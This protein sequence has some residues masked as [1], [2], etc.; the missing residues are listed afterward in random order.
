[1]RAGGTDLELDV[2]EHS[3]EHPARRVGDID[4]GQECPGACVDRTGGAGHR[5]RH[6]LHELPSDRHPDRQTDGHV[7]RVCLG[8]VDEHAERVDLRN[9]EQP[10]RDAGHAGRRRRGIVDR[11]AR[12]DQRAHVHVALDHRAV[13]GRQDALERRQLAQSLDV[14]LVRLDIRLRRGDRGLARAIRR[15][16][17]IDDQLGDRLFRIGRLVARHR[18]PREIEVGLLQIQ[19]L[20]GLPEVGFGLPQLLVDLGRRD[21]GQELARRHVVPDVHV[22]LAEVPAGAGVDDRVL[23]GLGRGGQ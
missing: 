18:G 4:L 19:V 1:M 22:P 3:R 13:E 7:R 8:N 16:A 23:N 21:L 12:R 2:N 17:L 9:L 11:A 5:A 10:V 6:R 20:L 15:Y 14:G